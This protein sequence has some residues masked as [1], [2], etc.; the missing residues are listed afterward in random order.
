MPSSNA[1]ER[2]LAFNPMDG[3]T[4]EYLGHLLAF[5]GD[6]QRGCALAEKARHL[7]P[8]HPAWYWA[9]PF[10]DA[11]RQADYVTARAFM[12]KADMPGQFFSRGTA[13]GRV[14][15]AGGA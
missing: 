1:A 5:A 12:L 15:P 8:H 13:R 4:I 2:A 10:L 6:W 11:Y 3:A 14:R 9:L 7:N